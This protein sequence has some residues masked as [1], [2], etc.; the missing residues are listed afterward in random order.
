MKNFWQDRAQRAGSAALRRTFAAWSV[1]LASADQVNGN[2]PMVGATGA[3]FRVESLR[4]NASSGIA[5]DLNF[6]S[7]DHGAEAAEIGKP[8]CAF[9]RGGC[10]A[11]ARDDQIEERP[12]PRVWKE[13]R[14]GRTTP[15]I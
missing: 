3:L 9:L 10:K 7:A 4:S 5:I 8:G 13:F 2:R 1:Q 15:F 6:R 12:L 14:T 11:A